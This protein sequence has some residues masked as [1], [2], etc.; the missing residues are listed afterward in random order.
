M[1]KILLLLGLVSGSLFAQAPQNV[2]NVGQINWWGL[3]NCTWTSQSDGTINIP[4]VNLP[5]TGAI[6]PNSGGTVLTPSTLNTIQFAAWGDSLT[7]GCEAT[8]PSTNC[9]YPYALSQD[10]NTTVF[11]GGVG[12]ETS[13]QIAARQTAE[14]GDYGY[15]QIIWAGRNNYSSQATVLADIATMVGNLTSPKCFLVLSILNGYGNSESKGQSNYNLIIALNQAIQAAYPNNYLDIREALVADYDPTNP[16]DQYDYTLD[17]PP[18]S[19]RAL[20]LQGTI[21]QDINATQTSFTVSTCPLYGAMTIGLEK[22]TAIT[23]SGTTVSACTRGGYGTTPA[24]HANGTSFYGIDGIHLGYNGYQFVAQQVQRWFTAPNTISANGE[25][26]AT[27]PAPGRFTNVAAQ[28]IDLS[29]GPITIDSSGNTSL[30]NPILATSTTNQSSPKLKLGGTYWNAASLTDAWMIQSIPAFNNWTLN[31]N[32]QQ[33]PAYFY[34][35]ANFHAAGQVQTDY[36]LL[37]PLIKW[38]AACS[39]TASP[40]ACGAA[41][42][43]VVQMASGATSLIVDTSSATASSICQLTY[44]T[45][46]LTAPTNLSLLGSPVISAVSAGTSFTITAPVAPATNPINVNY[47]CTN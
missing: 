29:G 31:I 43:G 26:G 19:L 4:C 33:G 41:P 14:T 34:T 9:S 17:V 44:S 38:T 45:V 21:T 42:V 36:R 1:K 24:T 27:T 47:T 30:N 25:T 6:Q 23:C 28:A 20:E 18:S 5:A 22:I 39:Q 32:A 2:P 11:N 15:C 3:P 12:G 40:A 46:G 10:L 7:A 37:T 35:N 16:E 8:T 13:T